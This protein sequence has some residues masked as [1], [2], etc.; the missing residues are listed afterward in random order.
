M[1]KQDLKCVDYEF[2]KLSRIEI[3]ASSKKSK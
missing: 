3:D 1:I 2:K